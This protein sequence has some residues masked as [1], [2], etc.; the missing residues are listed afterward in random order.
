[1]FNK[2][3]HKLIMTQILKDIY[4]DVTI[5][6]LLGFKGG[7]AAY[8]FYELPR[9]SVDLD[10]DLLENSEENRDIIFERIHNILLKYGEI[11]DEQKKFFTV[12]FSLSYEIGEHQIKIEINT[13]ETGAHYEM[14][15]YFGIPMLVATK[16]S[17]FA[18]KLVAMTQRKEFVSRDL[19]D[20]HFFLKQ[21][22]DI[23]T[24]VLISYQITSLKIYLETCITFIEDVSNTVLLAGLGE[25]ID[26]KAKI[27]VKSHLKN[28]TIFLLKVRADLL[29]N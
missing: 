7:T 6:S 16:E 27:F 4:S 14:K 18:G 26:E 17:M 10:F 20:I 8:L 25:L 15:S 13:R 11:K 3:K 12:F 22:W 2:D 9:F 1:M 24:D 28:D 21:M 5:S 29:K 23:D 19:Y